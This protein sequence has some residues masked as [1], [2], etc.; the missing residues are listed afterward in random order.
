MSDNLDAIH[1]AYKAKVEA[2]LAHGE[3]DESVF[4]DKPEGFSKW[5]KQHPNELQ[6]P[7]PEH[8][9]TTQCWNCGKEYNRNK[10]PYCKAFK[11][12]K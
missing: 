2:R 3:P 5:L 1:R 6:L 4:R 7:K 8:I 9:P 12:R 11:P 10:C